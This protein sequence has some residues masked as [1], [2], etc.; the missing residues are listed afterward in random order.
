MVYLLVLV[1][2]RSFLPVKV[3]QVDG[4]SPSAIRHVSPPNQPSNNGAAEVFSVAPMMGHTT[5]HY[6]S[7]FGKLSQQAWL[8]TEMIPANRIVQSYLAAV[9]ARSSKSMDASML[10]LPE[11]ILFHVDGMKRDHRNG[12]TFNDVVLDE[13]LNPGPN[14]AVLQ[15]GGRDPVS[16]SQA[17]A[18]GTAFGFQAINLNC[19]CPS[20][21]VSAR[22]TGAV[23]MKE[24]MVVARCLEAMSKSIDAIN[25]STILSVKHRLGVHE[26][27]TY[28]ADLDHAQDDQEAYQSCHDFVRCI[29][30]TSKLSSIQVHARIALLG[31][32]TNTGDDKQPH[33]ALW[34]PNSNPTSFVSSTPTV[35]L[36]QEQSSTVKMNHQRIQYQAK[37]RARQVTLQ[38]RSV[39]PLRPNV[40][41]QI[42]NEFPSLQVISNGGVD[43]LDEFQRRTKNTS[44]MG[45]MVGRAVINHPC[46]FVAVDDIVGTGT[47]WNDAKTRRTVLLS[48]IEY[49][50]EQESKLEQCTRM[51]PGEP[52]T[53]KRKS[54][55]EDSIV[56]HRRRLLAPV[57]HL[58]MGEEG[59]DQYQRRLRKL[60]ERGDRHTT[61]SMLLAAMAQIPDT[62]LDKPIHEHVP[63]DEIPKYDF[64]KRSGS[65]QRTI[66]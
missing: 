23:L 50:L 41:E 45:V 7:F 24:P 15:L 62:V 10:L 56:W 14:P 43:C 58:F 5:S 55:E 47:P 6:R 63:W 28:N 37:R 18:I 51:S 16:L 13:L 40:V 64:V 25:P 57:F 31:L 52:I 17:A 34:T 35:T 20:T 42:A 12:V 3:Y 22:A 66:Y 46:A 21:S 9:A 4:L 26:A 32:N 11:A 65:I 19:G 33:D 44:V 8:Y 1:Y 30:S 38:N 39:P 60:L 49:C 29:S 27:N 53:N 59:N 48:Y 36:Q 54:Q 2:Y 61:S